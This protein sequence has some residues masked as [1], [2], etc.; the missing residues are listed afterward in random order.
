[1]FH[2]LASIWPLDQAAA[3]PLLK[4][5]ARVETVEAMAVMESPRASEATINH[6]LVVEQVALTL[7]TQTRSRVFQ[8]ALE[9]QAVEATQTLQA[10]QTP[11]AEEE[12]GAHQITHPLH[13]LAATA[14]PELS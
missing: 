11:V 7:L 5:L 1:M 3:A 8:T 12:V 4:G 10:R 9:A 13:F 6:S 2:P 14:A